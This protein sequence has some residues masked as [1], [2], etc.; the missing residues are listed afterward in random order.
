METRVSVTTLFRSGFVGSRALARLGQIQ[1]LTAL[2]CVGLMAHGAAITSAGSGDWSNT[3]TWT[4]GVVPGIGDTVTVQATHHVLVDVN[5]VVGTSP[6]DTTPVI[7]V[8]STGS[9]EVAD[10][11]TLESRGS[12]ALNNSPMTVGCGSIL[13][14]NASNATTPTTNYQILIGTSASQANAR[15]IVDGC[16]GNRGTVR[17]NAG[18]GNASFVRTGTGNGQITANQFTFERLGTATIPSMEISAGMSTYTFSLTNGTITDSGFIDATMTNPNMASVVIVSGVTTRNNLHASRVWYFRGRADFTTGYGV[19]THNRNL[20]NKSFDASNF[21]GYTV[22]D[23]MNVGQ[24]FFSSNPPVSYRWNI[25]RNHSNGGN[26]LS[27]NGTA[28]DSFFFTP[29]TSTNAHFITPQAG[30]TVDGCIFE[31][32]STSAENGDLINFGGSAGTRSARNNISLPNNET[33]RGASG[34][35]SSALGGAGINMQFEKNTIT[36][37]DQSEDC[38]GGFRQAETYAGHADMYP[39]VRSNAFWVTGKGTRPHKMFP[40]T[41]SGFVDAVSAANANYNGGDPSQISASSSAGKGYQMSFS[42]GSPGANDLEENPRLVDDTRSL[43]RWYAYLTGTAFVAGDGGGSSHMNALIEIGK[44]NDVSGFDP[45]FTIEAAHNWVRQGFA[46]RNLKYATG[47]HDGG[48][49][50][51]VPVRPMFGAF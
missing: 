2:L 42:S 38:G 24:I 16:V 3:A 20:D 18:G 27:V 51:A 25:S 31:A 12:I 15:F 28:R 44:R 29:G 36:L 34:C 1:R 41:G 48:R 50:G 23:N 13:E 10:G 45:R 6:S 19:F 4:G 22:E 37:G 14:M 9:L 46:P 17:S 5:S 33:P 32:M 26:S 21:G 7:T 40:A 39:Y 49:I 35:F 11:V 30:S 47:G 8:S 43:G